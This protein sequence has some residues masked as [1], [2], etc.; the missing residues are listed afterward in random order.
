MYDFFPSLIQALLIMLISPLCIGI[1]KKTK[2]L[3]Q[4]RQGA[5]ILQL[6]FDLYK[7][8]QKDLYYSPVATYIF[9]FAPLVFLAT[10]IVAALLLPN[11]FNTWNIGDIFVLLYFLAAGRFF[12]TIAALDTATTF[13]GMGSSREVYLATLIEPVMLLAILIIFKTTDTSLLANISIFSATQPINIST[14][15]AMLGFF[16]LILAENGRIPIDNPDTHLE[17]TMI[18]EGM[19]LEYSSKLLV[20]IH[21]AAYSKQVLFCIIFASLFFV[22]TLPLFVKVFLTLVFTGITET[23]NNKMRLFRI[24]NYIIIAGVLIILSLIS[25]KTIL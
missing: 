18:H 4:N 11:P 10:T 20:F 1:T 23:L 7:W 25:H 5:S 2:A 19:T 8:W 24:P 13:G 22:G 3:L 21:L 6:Y 14:T 16:M 12:M 17:L 9:I 15:L